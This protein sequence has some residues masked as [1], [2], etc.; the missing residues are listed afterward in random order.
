LPRLPIT[1]FSFIFCPTLG[2]LSVSFHLVMPFL[3]SSFFS[4][5]FLFSFSWISQTPERSF[6]RSLLFRYQIRFPHL[7]FL[8]FFLISSFPL[9]FPGPARLFLQAR[10]WIFVLQTPPPLRSLFNVPSFLLV[11]PARSFPALACRFSKQTPR[12]HSTQL[13]QSTWLSYR[14]IR[15]GF[16]F[17]RPR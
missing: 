5:F 2:P 8:F 12:V 17:T 10:V 1:L 3:G 11:L 4:C 6:P 15:H 16:F 9:F 13:C 7:S 14:P